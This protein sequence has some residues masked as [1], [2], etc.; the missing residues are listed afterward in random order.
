MILF[1][2][3]FNIVAVMIDRLPWRKKHIPFLTAHIGILLVCTG[4]LLTKYY[5]IDGNM[6]IAL[7][8]KKTT[9]ITS[10][11]L[12]AIYSSFNGQNLT[13]LYSKKVKFFRNPPSLNKP[14]KIPIAS[15]SHLKITGYY[16]FATARENYKKPKQNTAG[17]N[18]GVAIRFQLKGTQANIVS[19]LFKAPSQKE[20]RHI[21]GPAQI[22]LTKKLKTPPPKKIKKN[23]LIIAPLNNKYLHYKLYHSLSDKTTTGR[24]K[25]GSVLA[26]GWMDF[27]LRIL[28]YLPKA[29][30]DMIFTPQKKFNKNTTP[31]IQVTFKKQQQWMGLNSHLFFFEK[32]K[33]FIVAYV[34]NK[35]KLDFNIQLKK[36]KIKKYPSSQKALSYKSTVLI[37]KK[38][39]Q[40]P[41]KYVISMNEPLK[42]SGY[43]IYQSGFEEDINGLPQASILAINKDPGRWLKYIGSLLIVIGSLLLFLKKYF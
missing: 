32:D 14:Y 5:G 40:L 13:E 2:L 41:T 7:G 21:Y 18:T 19:W 22:I 11:T 30:P 36:F 12:L 33:V 9:I 34:N 35:K 1:L 24:L 15:S 3:A 38:N 29:L 20:S 17:Q 16:P 25:L 27:K 31:A 8:E 4:A 23:T 28:S 43:T 10:D 37:D 39:H 6:R 26:T 42:Q